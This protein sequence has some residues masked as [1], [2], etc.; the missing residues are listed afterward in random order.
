MKI[1]GKDCKRGNCN[2]YPCK[3]EK[4][5]R[6][7]TFDRNLKWYIADEQ[8]TAELNLRMN[9]M[10]YWELRNNRYIY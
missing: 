10:L 6:E 9:K 8:E 1:N 3:R 4:C 2:L 5:T 7:L